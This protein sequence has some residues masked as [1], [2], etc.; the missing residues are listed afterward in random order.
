MSCY[1]RSMH[2]L[3]EAL[4]L[5][6]DKPSRKRV[7]AAIREVLGSPADAHCPEVWAAIKGLSEA[8]RADLT[9]RVAELLAR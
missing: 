2:W 9:P 4:D 1:L 3:F 8:E 5:E 7:D 6:Y